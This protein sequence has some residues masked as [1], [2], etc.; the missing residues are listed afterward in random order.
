MTVFDCVT[1]T[2]SG[3]IIEVTNDIYINSSAILVPE[4]DCVAVYYFMKDVSCAYQMTD[5]VGLSNNYNTW[6]RKVYDPVSGTFLRVAEGINPEEELIWIRHPYLIDP[7]VTDF[8][9]ADF[10]YTDLAGVTKDYRIYGY[11]VDGDKNFETTSDREL[12][13]QLTN[14]TDNRSYYPVPIDAGRESILDPK[15]TKLDG[16]VYLTWL[17]NGTIFNTISAY[18]LFYGLDHEDGTAQGRDS[19]L[20]FSSLD[21][22]RAL[23]P[24]MIAAEGWYKLPYYDI[25]EKYRDSIEDPKVFNSMLYKF[26]LSSFISSSHDFGSIGADGTQ[27]GMILTHHSLV[28]GRDGN[29]YL[30]WT[31]QDNEDLQYDFSRELYGA[32]MYRQSSAAGFGRAVLG[33]VFDGTL[34]A[35]SSAEEKKGTPVWSD[36]VKLTDY[37]KVIDELTVSVA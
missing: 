31:A 12:W 27:D 21:R 23:S 5:L 37:G 14:L 10:S 7:M 4:K 20:S 30:F 24:D 22:I 2:F 1:Q 13:V 26:S 32:A 33:D 16:D 19:A 35:L 29:L 3:E 6:A 25:V 9:A 11:T 8:T 34:G 28:P 36:P 15:L 18:N 17:D